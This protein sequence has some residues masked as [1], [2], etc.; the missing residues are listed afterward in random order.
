M[1]ECR[2][3][4]L[5]VSPV[6]DDIE[7]ES[8]VQG[9]ESEQ[10]P[11]GQGGVSENSD[12]SSSSSSEEEDNNEA[13]PVKAA[14][15]PA[16]PSKAEMDEHM[17]SHLPFRSWCAHCVK[18]KSK[19]KRHPYTAQS[20]DHEMPMVTIDYM[21]LNSEG[22]S[23]DE[24]SMPTLVVKDVLSPH[25][26]TGMLFAHVVP[27]KGANSYAINILSKDIAILGHPELILK[28]DN[29][30]AIIALKEATKRERSERIVF[31][32]PPVKESQANGAI[33]NA[34][35]QVQGQFRAM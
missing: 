32:S 34:V 7:G 16:R 27:H 23:S 24:S 29:E 35:Q 30:P 11:L 17:L 18:G 15:K 25:C 4:D 20:S 12:N 33:E 8:I 1:N 2:S 31:E 10:Q 9:G 21:F 14:P 5:F 3:H 28:S 19:S 6:V 13:I 26:G 22:S